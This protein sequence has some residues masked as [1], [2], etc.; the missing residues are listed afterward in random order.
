LTCILKDVLDI[1]NKGGHREE[2]E[3]TFY[4][5]VDQWERVVEGNTTQQ[6]VKKTKLT[7]PTFWD[8]MKIS[9][10]LLTIYIK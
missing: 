10:Y 4:N 1:S 9:F 5:V 3:K 7:V 6:N 2:K 8:H